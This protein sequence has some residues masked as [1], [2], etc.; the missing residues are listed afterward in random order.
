MSL[1]LTAMACWIEEG[2]FDSHLCYVLEELI[3][4]ACDIE[5]QYLALYKL[6]R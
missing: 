2:K 1:F 6:C 5:K 3:F 4:W